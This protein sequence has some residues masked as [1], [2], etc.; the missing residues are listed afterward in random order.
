MVQNIL[1]SKCSLIF[2][3]HPKF[4]LYDVQ[5]LFLKLISIC[6]KIK[7][8]AT[9]NTYETKSLFKRSSTVGIKTK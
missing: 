6:K 2:R 4:E 3:L 7:F 1:Q 5:A 8:S 9:I